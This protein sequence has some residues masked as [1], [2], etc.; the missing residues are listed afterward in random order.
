[1]RDKFWTR[2]YTHNKHAHTQAKGDTEP[3]TANNISCDVPKGWFHQQTEFARTPVT[4]SSD[5]E[6]H[7]LTKST[8][9]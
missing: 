3:T 6:T 8:F 7:T 5:R 9:G 2:Q 1:M 4:Q